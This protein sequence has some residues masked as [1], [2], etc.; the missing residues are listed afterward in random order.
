MNKLRMFVVTHKY[1]SLND[2]ERIPILVGKNKDSIS[3]PSFFTDSTG[4][5][6]SSKNAS[7]CELTALYWIW[8]NDDSDYISFEH[9]RRFFLSNKNRLLNKK[10]CKKEALSL[11]NSCD[12]IIPTLKK[13]K[14]SNY[15]RYVMN[16]N[17]NHIKNDLDVTINLI[18]KIYPEMSDFVDKY[19]KSNYSTYYNMF[20]G[21]KHVI[22][23]YCDWLFDLFNK[24]EPLIQC[25]RTG[26]QKR[27]FGYLSER[28]FN[29]WIMYK[30]I[31][32]KYLDVIYTDASLK[33]KIKQYLLHIFNKKR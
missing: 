10:I 15:D 13:T 3:F 18:K 33:S 9:Y 16:I 27:V 21:K 5:N 30:G 29:I 1:F 2:S 14:E 25:E 6:I 11:L 8:K 24:L 22:D 28:L 19:F 12:L 4:D 23:E 32:V 31:N 17:N 20:I 26:N 7:Y